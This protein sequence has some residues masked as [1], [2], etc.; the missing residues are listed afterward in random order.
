MKKKNRS[1]S[2]LF[3]A[4][5]KNFFKI[6]V[7]YPKMVFMALHP[8][9]YTDEEKYTYGIRM[10]KHALASTKI[11]IEAYGLENIPPKGGLYVCANHQEKFDPLAIWATF[12]QQIGVILDDVAT[13]RPFISEICKLIR[14]QKLI[15]NDNHSIIQAYTQITS[16]L[17]NG[18]NYMIF[19]EGGYEEE[20]GVLGEFH[21][22]SF[23][24]PQRAHCTIL[25]VAIIDSF[26]IF[27]KGFKTTL[28]IQIHYLKPIL[29]EEYEGMSTTEIAE[30]VKSRIQAHLD[31][32]QK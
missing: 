13:H 23:K 17:K 6:L 11:K 4:I 9:K 21:A 27:D 19:P 31:I 32:Y 28:P 1:A 25:P 16:D 18:Y 2:I 26:R 12:P 5:S 7:F 22:G 30:L 14:S 15:K 24:S 8:K 29:P 3:K 10:V 20:D